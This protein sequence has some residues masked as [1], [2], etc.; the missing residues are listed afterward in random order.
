MTDSPAC[1]ACGKT[2]QEGDERCSACG[3]QRSEGEFAP[4]QSYGATWVLSGSPSAGEREDTPAWGGV[5]ATPPADQD[6]PPPADQDAP[7]P[8]DQDA[9][10]PAPDRDGWQEVRGQLEKA[11]QGE[12]EVLKELGRGGMAAVYLARDLALGRNVAIKVMAPGLLLGPGMVDRFR[13]EAVTVANLHHPNIVTIHTVRQAGRL[14][15]FVMQVVEGGSLET[16]LERP[17]PLPVPLIQVILFQVGTGLSYAHRHGV[18]H[19]DIKPANVLLDG[20]GNAILTD[21]GIAKV[22]TATNLTQTGST[23]GTPSYMSPEQCRAGELSNASDQYSLGVVA[24]EMLSGEPPFSGAAFEI[25]QAHNSE[26]PAALRGRSPDCPPELEAAVLKMLAKDPEQRFPS[27]AEAIEAIGGYIPGP[28]DPVRLELARLAGPGVPRAPVEPSPPGPIPLGATVAAPAE[29]VSAT[30]EPQRPGPTRPKVKT[31]WA[32]PRVLVGGALGLAVIV[33]SAV[34]FLQGLTPGE[35]ES[36]APA[37]LLLNTVSFPSAPEEILVGETTGIRVLFQDPDGVAVTGESIT[38]VSDDP[39]VASVEG[40][41]EEGRVAGLS[42]GSA[43]IQA[44][45]GGVVGTFNL[46]VSATT[47]GQLTASAPRR[48]VFI[49]GMINLSAE[50]LDPSGQP[51]SD[52][53]ITWA[54]SDPAIVEVDRETGRATGR[55]LGRARLTASSGDQTGSVSLQVMGRVEAMTVH[56]PLDHL[57]VGGTSVVRTSVT[58]QPAGYLGAEGIRWSS[59]DPTV[60]RVSSFAGDSVVLAFLGEGEVVLTARADAVEGTV[61]LQVDAPA[62]AVTLSLLPVSVSFEV[63]EEG[64]TPEER[65]VEVRITGDAP[66]SVGVVAYGGGAG[67]WVRQ[68]LG[69]GPSGGTALTVGVELEGLVPGTYTANIPIGAGGQTQTLGVQLIVAPDPGLG[70]VEP[71]DAAATEISTLLGAYLGALNTKDTRR[72]LELFPSLSQSAIDELLGLPDSD[73]Y[74]IALQPGSLRAGAQEETLDGEVM[75][76]VVGPSGQGE[77]RLVVYTFGRGER[78]WFIVAFRAG[79]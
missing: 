19:L 24:Y 48:E 66:P 5:G 51:I 46:L 49:G 11:T 30:A 55:G 15:F 18:I 68:S 33:T 32:R 75:S 61:T 73:Q 6:V 36:A 44:S 7:P 8:T 58:S 9:P 57:E 23:I 1:R 56:P 21:F 29:T 4:G 43:I 10:P 54:S 25:M 74:Y 45:A 16:L 37:T 72:V 53:T 26:A 60:A 62:P 17:E 2:F 76:G 41:G 63:V 20:E 14:H 12:F 52:V 79:G 47:P 78:G 34:A 39:S 40:F 28:R 42:P 64:A 67:G 35:S 50:L 27:V 59:S 70:H 22:A 13:Q 77:L 38:W 65:T 69:T 3:A 71:T 31:N